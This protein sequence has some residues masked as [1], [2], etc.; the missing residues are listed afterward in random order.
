MKKLLFL[1]IFGLFIAM[2]ADAAQPQPRLGMPGAVLPAA[3]TSH[4]QILAGLMDGTDADMEQKDAEKLADATLA[5]ARAGFDEASLLKLR[6]LC[7]SIS[8][9]A[10]QAESRL[11]KCLAALE[12]PGFTERIGTRVGGALG[13]GIDTIASG[14]KSICSWG[15]WGAKGVGYY[16]VA[17]PIYYG[18]KYLVVKPTAW[19]YKKAKDILWNKKAALIAVI[20][21]T[22]LAVV[23]VTLEALNRHDMLPGADARFWVGVDLDGHWDAAGRFV[24]RRIANVHGAYDAIPTG[25]EAIA[26]LKVFYQYLAGQSKAAW[27]RD[28]LWTHSIWDKVS[29]IYTEVAKGIHAARTQEFRDAPEVIRNQT[30]VIENLN[31]TL[32]EVRTQLTKKAEVAEDTLLQVCKKWQ[33]LTMAVGNGNKAFIQETCDTVLR[34]EA[35]RQAILKA[36]ADTAARL[37]QAT[38]AAATAAARAAKL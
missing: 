34:N 14:I 20:T 1:S 33:S 11:K 24:N 3:D 30:T 29:G 18:G 7:E 27:E 5:I 12:T 28:T 31:A 37:A 9:D 25:E 35:E 6:T 16:G 32:K 13:S 4:A 26:Q 8:A 38:Q 36:A 10:A 2:T 22:T 21:L 23:I 15:Y 19:T 17:M